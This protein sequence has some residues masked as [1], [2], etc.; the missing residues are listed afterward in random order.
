MPPSCSRNSRPGRAAR[1]RSA[2]RHRCPLEGVRPY[3]PSEDRLR[4]P[5]ALL[6]TLSAAST[7]CPLPRQPCAGRLCRLPPA[8]RGLRPFLPAWLPG[9]AAGA[10]AAVPSTVLTPLP[11][12]SSLSSRVTHPGAGGGAPKSCAL[13]RRGGKLLVPGHIFRAK[14]FV[15]RTQGA[16]WS[17]GLCTPHAGRVCRGLDGRPWGGQ[18][19]WGH[20]QGRRLCPLCPPAAQGPD[21]RR[22]KVRQRLWPQPCLSPPR[23]AGSCS[24][25]R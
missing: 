24:R 6:L 4:L 12:P 21:L 13:Q 19:P 22:H 20:S 3:P 17:L 25:R 15:P 2:Q 16:L 10:W 7:P 8:A 9:R 11:H 5:P 23:G 18:A 14:T 1:S